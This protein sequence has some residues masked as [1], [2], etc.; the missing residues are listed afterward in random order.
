M[1]QSF[2]VSSKN[3]EL[4][5]TLKASKADAVF[6][7]FYLDFVGIDQIQW[8]I[9]G[10]FQ[11]EHEAN[12]VDTESEELELLNGNRWKENRP[13]VLFWTGR[14]RTWMFMP[15]GTK[16]RMICFSLL[17]LLLVEAWMSGEWKRTCS[18]I[19]E[20]PMLSVRSC[21]NPVWPRKLNHWQGTLRE[22]RRNSS[23]LHCGSS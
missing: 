18:F 1:S 8:E 13:E 12:C 3:D 10:E 4:L 14:G 7:K 23:W 17:L 16:T 22:K 9:K 5:P 20:Q 2:C 6:L 21:W 15:E 11:K 19:S